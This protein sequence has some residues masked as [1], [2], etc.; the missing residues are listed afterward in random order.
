MPPTNRQI[1]LAYVSNMESRGKKRATLE[2]AAL[3]L[4]NR[5]LP[6][7]DDLLDDIAEELRR[8]YG[9]IEAKVVSAKPISD[10]NRENILAYIK[11]TVGA[12]HVNLEESVNGDLL[13]GA[14]ISTPD[15]ELDLSLKTKLSKLQA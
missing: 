9:L 14:I 10:K 11:R 2:L 15:Y 7:L 12:Q 1:A 3:I 6:R 5:L 8:K 13:G 4:E